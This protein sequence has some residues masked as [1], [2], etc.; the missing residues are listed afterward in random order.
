MPALAS[1]LDKKENM[2]IISF[3]ESCLLFNFLNRYLLTRYVSLSIFEILHSLYK[4][5]YINLTCRSEVND[6]NLSKNSRC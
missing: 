2:T 5:K 1:K 4:D 6:L 3:N